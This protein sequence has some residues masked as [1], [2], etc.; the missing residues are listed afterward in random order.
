MGLCENFGVDS[1]VE[2]EDVLESDEVSPS[3]SEHSQERAERDNIVNAPVGLTRFAVGFHI[4]FKGVGA[5][6]L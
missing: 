1:G 3:E 4:L 6:F 5:A 2:L